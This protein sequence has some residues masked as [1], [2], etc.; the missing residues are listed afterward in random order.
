MGAPVIFG[1]LLIAIL[2][3]I[4]WS[5]LRRM[6]VPDRLNLALA[7]TGLA[8][9]LFAA[10]A[11][12]WLHAATGA[13]ALAAFWLV[14]RVHAAATGRI[15]LGLGDVKMAGAA[16]IWIS[17]WNLPLFV[18]VASAAAL[19]VA[20]GRHLLYRR[21]SADTRQPFAPFLGAGLLVTWLAEQQNPSLGGF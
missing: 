7:A 20:T 21:L 15:G 14:R 2:G 11:A 4:A 5:D 19:A 6:I 12:P 16:A 10:P 13:V 9:Q 17:P 18:F 8:Y 1:V 3:A